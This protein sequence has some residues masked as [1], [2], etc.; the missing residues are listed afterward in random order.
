MSLHYKLTK[1]NCATFIQ[2]AWQNTTEDFTKAEKC[3][4][5]MPP[6]H[7]N[8][9]H[10]GPFCNGCIVGNVVSEVAC[11]RAQIDTVLTGSGSESEHA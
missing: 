7:Q 9:I 1:T 5:N 4:A 6:E 10:F 3:Q 11:S 8:T 2:N